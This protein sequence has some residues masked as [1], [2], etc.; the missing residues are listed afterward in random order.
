M[1]QGLTIF[2]QLMDTLL[3][4]YDFDQIVAQYRGDHRVRS[5][6]CR[7]QFQ[8]M[9][10]AQLTGRE[11]LRDIQNRL[12]ALRSKLYHAGFRGPVSRNTLAD[13]NERRPWRL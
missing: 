8:A 13:A 2:A 5:F 1:N 11:S 7:D 10:F 12:S 6:S 3:S 9:A 4:Q